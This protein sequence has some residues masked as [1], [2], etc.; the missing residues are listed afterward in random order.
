MFI[1]IS[2]EIIIL[3][4]STFPIQDIIKLFEA[5]LII[6]EVGKNTANCVW[7]YQEYLTLKEV[8]DIML[9]ESVGQKTI[10]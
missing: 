3:K 1:N 2:F 9:I 10:V 8:E 4:K 7:M 5:N 6:T